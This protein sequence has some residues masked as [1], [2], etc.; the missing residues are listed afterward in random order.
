MAGCSGRT[1]VPLCYPSATCGVASSMITWPPFGIS[2]ATSV[3]WP[4]APAS[5]LPGHSIPS[6]PPAPG[7]ATHGRARSTSEPKPCSVNCS[8]RNWTSCALCRAT[9]RPDEN[10]EGGMHRPSAQ[11][12]QTVATVAFGE[13]AP[14]PHALG[15][16]HRSGARQFPASCRHAG[17]EVGP[18]S[19][20]F[21]PGLQR[22]G[23]RRPRPS[24][25]R[26]KRLRNRVATCMMRSLQP[27]SLL[28]RKRK[29]LRWV[30]MVPPRGEAV[31]VRV[32]ARMVSCLACRWRWRR[33]EWAL[34]EHPRWLR[35]LA[36]RSCRYR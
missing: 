12:R 30:A 11:P 9:R 18:S 14:P 21:P 28:V 4:A 32:T 1:H 29:V 6:W 27:R 25:Y 24:G 23:P 10:P 33:S 17:R 13:T 8:D 16:L 35:L 19:A 31:S 20:W 3:N 22:K 5:G 15:Q 34:S 26:L 7:T 36:R 2:R